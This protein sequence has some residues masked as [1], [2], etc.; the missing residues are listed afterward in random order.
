MPPPI[1]AKPRTPNPT[2]NARIG[3]NP[4]GQSVVTMTTVAARSP[5]PAPINAPRRKARA[6][7]RSRSEVRRA[8]TGRTAATLSL[9]GPGIE[10][11]V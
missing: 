8:S 3:Q 7:F 1:A 9:R 4:F 6:S 5:T 2:A 11:L 10:L